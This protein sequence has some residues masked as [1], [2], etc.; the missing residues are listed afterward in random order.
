VGQ[1]KLAS[2]V[3]SVLSIVFGWTLFAFWWIYV[4]EHSDAT[5]VLLAVGAVLVIA[6]VFIACAWAWISHNQRLA[7]RGTRGLATPYRAAR[8]ERDG[9]NR[10]LILPARETLMEA[11]VVLVTADADEKTYS[12]EPYAPFP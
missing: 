4:L 5:N 9:I 1:V 11:A 7:R 12:S 8:F 3:W 10:Q 2:V 6:L